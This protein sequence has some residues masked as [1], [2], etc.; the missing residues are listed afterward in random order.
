MK[1]RIIKLFLNFIIKIRNFRIFNAR[2][3]QYRSIL[4]RHYSPEKEVEGEIEYLN[5]WKQLTNKVEPY[6]YRLFSHY[7]GEVPH[8]VPDYIG[9]EIISYYLNPQRYIDF[10]E[11]KNT[12]DSYILLNDS[13]PKTYAKRISGGSMLLVDNDSFYQANQMSINDHLKNLGVDKCVLKP[14]IDSCS[15]NGVMMFQKGNGSY[16]STKGVIL[17]NAFLE[18]F[19]DDFVIQEAIIQHP[20]LAKFNPTSVNTLRICTYRSVKDERIEVTGALIRIGKQ[21][22]IVDNAHAGGCFVGID[23]ESGHLHHYACDQYGNKYESWNSTSFAVAYKIPNWDI[24]KEFARRVASYNHHCRLLALDITVDADGR[25]RLIEINISG[26]SFWLFY[27]CG[28]DVFNGE[29]QSVIDYCNAKMNKD[30]RKK[31][32]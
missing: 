8:I 6:S 10:Y 27:F 30:G 15:G 4:K 16:V 18:S 7:I 2:K 1:K 13:L 14:T 9:T 17:S 29:H 25:P 28:Q 11:D 3:K 20:D 32:I 22:E 26:F 12:Y 23:L 31:L 5:L 24:V 19:S 21:G